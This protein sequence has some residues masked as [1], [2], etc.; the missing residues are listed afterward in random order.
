MIRGNHE[1]QTINTIYGFKEECRKRIDGEDVDRVFDPDGQEMRLFE[2]NRQQV[3]QKPDFSFWHVTNDTFEWL[4]CGQLIDE[5]VLCIHGGIGAK[6]H[7]IQDIA[8]EYGQNSKGAAD[9]YPLLPLP[10]I[11]T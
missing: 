10:P 11:S 8:Q 9:R 3:Q 5:K 1:D 4:P 7:Y 6:I 2:T